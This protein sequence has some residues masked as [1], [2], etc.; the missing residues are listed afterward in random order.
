ML[1]KAEVPTPPPPRAS[2]EN[3]PCRHLDFFSVELNL[4]FWHPELEENEYVSKVTK[5]VAVCYSS[6]QEMN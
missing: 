6:T 1:K 3:Q 5:L 2:S 4:D